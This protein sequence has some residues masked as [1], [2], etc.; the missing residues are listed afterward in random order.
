MAAISLSIDDEYSSILAVSSR[1]QAIHTSHSTNHHNEE[2]SRQK[3][4]SQLTY[5]APSTKPTHLCPFTHPR[6]PK[7]CVRLY[8]VQ[9]VNISC[10]SSY[11]RQGRQAGISTKPDWL[12]LPIPFQSKKPSQVPK[13]KKP[14]AQMKTS[15]SKRTVG[16][17]SLNKQTINAFGYAKMRESNR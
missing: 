15:Q 17:K 8:S 11:W 6:T 4:A 9:R 12:A 2:S 16:G 1:H 7:T 13:G 10:P 3:P 14:L 5:T